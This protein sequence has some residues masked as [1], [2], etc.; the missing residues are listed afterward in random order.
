MTE[1]QLQ[2]AIR[3]ALGRD[4]ELV[5]FR[6]NIGSAVMRGGY[7]VTFGVGGPGGADL[8]GMFRGRF[9][10]IE[11]K[12]PAGRQSKEQQLFEGLV[13]SK[14]G[15]YIMPRSVDEAVSAIA[16]LRAGGST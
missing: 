1:G 3:L 15:I 14:G 4:P 7:R 10:A 6:N 8:I 13:R 16:A 5:T 11:V 2:D 9:L 12:T